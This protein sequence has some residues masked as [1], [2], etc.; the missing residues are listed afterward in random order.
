MIIQQLEGEKWSIKQ[1]RIH[2]S[3]CPSLIKKPIKELNL[4][5]NCREKKR[6]VVGHAYNSYTIN[7]RGRSK[8]HKQK[9]H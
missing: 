7:H 3:L 1:L 4:I 9:F 5:I 6:E 2:H 8:L